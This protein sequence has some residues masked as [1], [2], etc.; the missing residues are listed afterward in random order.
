MMKRPKSRGRWKHSTRGPAFDSFLTRARLT[1]WALRVSLGEYRGHGLCVVAYHSHQPVRTHTWLS[2]YDSTVGAGPPLAEME[3]I[4]CC[5]SLCMGAW[6]QAPS[7]T[8]SSMH[9]ASTMNTPGATETSMSGSTGKMSHQVSSY[10]IY[11]ETGMGRVAFWQMFIWFNLC[12]CRFILQN[13]LTTLTKWTLTTWIH[14][15][16]ILLWCSMEGNMFVLSLS[17]CKLRH[18]I[19]FIR[20]LMLSCRLGLKY[21]WEYGAI[22]TFIWNHVL[23]HYVHQI[24]YFLV[25]V[26]QV[27]YSLLFCHFNLF[28]ITQNRWQKRPKH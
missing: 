1:S 15:T 3:A 25:C 23:C 21:Q 14:H 13:K 9:W 17:C 10:S 4:R 16:T 8:S 19:E 2:V 24:V 26:G 18:F 11:I 12:P 5:L 7:S 22:F 28:E 27:A 6:I 20:F